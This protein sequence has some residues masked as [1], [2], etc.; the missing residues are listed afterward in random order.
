MPALLIVTIAQEPAHSLYQLAFSC[1]P[2]VAAPSFASSLVFGMHEHPWFPKPRKPNDAC[3]AASM[4]NTGFVALPVLQAIYGP[5]AVCQAAIAHRICGCCDVSSSR[6][7][8]RTWPQPGRAWHRPTHG[9]NDYWLSTLCLL[10]RMVIINSDGACFCQSSVLRMP[11]AAVTA[12]LG[13]PGRR[14]HALCSVRHRTGAVHRW[15]ARQYWASFAACAAVKLV[16]MPLM[17]Y[18]LS[19]SLGLD[20]PLHTLRAVIWRRSAHGEDRLHS[21]GRVP[22]RG[23]DGSVHCLDDNS[24]VRHLA[25]GLALCAIRASQHASLLDRGRKRSGRPSVLPRPVP[26]F[27]LELGFRFAGRRPGGAE[28][29]DKSGAQ[30]AY[31]A[32]RAIIC[33]ARRPHR[34][35]L[36]E[37]QWNRSAADVE[38]EDQ[39]PAAPFVTYSMD[40][41]LLRRA[42]TTAAAK[43]EVGAHGEHVV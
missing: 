1:W 42:L 25:R 6:D 2:L 21:G 28:V 27:Y 8:A 32:R 9:P 24:S 29:A 34:N 13:N 30:K 22:L 19:V 12:Y 15:I 17:V 16:I 7:P 38:A 41:P 36:L 39:P 31:C 20:P 14:A 43:L 40:C 10:T 18:G 26:R 11:A 5:R 37:G 33:R 35:R 23:N 3:M 4:T